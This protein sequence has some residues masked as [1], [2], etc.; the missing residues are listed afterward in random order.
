MCLA[1]FADE[2]TRVQKSLL[3]KIP[4]PWTSEPKLQKGP[5]EKV[6]ISSIM[7][8]LSCFPFQEPSNL[9]AGSSL[10]P[11]GTSLAYKML[12]GRYFPLGMPLSPP[13]VHLS[14]CSV[15]HLNLNH[16]RGVKVLSL[17]VVITLLGEI[18]SLFTFFLLQCQGLLSF[19]RWILDPL[20]EE[21]CVGIYPG[22]RVSFEFQ[23][24]NSPETYRIT[25]T[26]VIRSTCFI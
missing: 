10:L 6:E 1:H 22:A 17:T 2:T 24:S 25:Y 3:G 9:L 23:L 14:E 19:S 4:S 21:L 20:D 16:N 8:K 18:P 7:G 15:S 13:S 5:W 12:P 11:P 26:S